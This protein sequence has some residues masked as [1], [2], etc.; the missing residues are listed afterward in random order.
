M[1]MM[2]DWLG[3][4][5]DPRRIALMQ[6]A[7]GLMGAKGGNLAQNIGQAGMMAIP[8]YQNAR[9]FNSREADAQL[10]RK[11]RQGQIDAQER[12]LAAQRSMDDLGRSAFA[13]AKTVQ[14]DP[15]EF[16]QM[17]QGTPQPQ[18]FSTPGG[19][20]LPA[21]VKGLMAIP[22]GPEKAIELQQRLAKDSPYGKLDPK[23]FTPESLR[24]FEASG[25]R[26]FTALRPRTKAEISNGV[27][28]DPY[29]T[30]PG[31]FI[32]GPLADVIPDGKGGW[33]PNP[34]KLALK[35][36]GA[37]NV[38]V[39]SGQAPFAKQ[40]GEKQADNIF[41]LHKSAGRAVETITTIH[42]MRDS[43]AGGMY[44]GGG[45]NTKAAI[46]NFLQPMGFAVNEDALAN[47]Q[48][49]NMAAG[50]FLLQHAKDLGANPSNADAARLDKIIGTAETNPQ[51]M[52]QLMDWQEE[53]ARRSIKKYNTVYDQV[54]KNPQI[55]NAYDMSVAEPGV[56]EPKQKQGGSAAP[57]I[58]GLSVTMPS[59]KVLTFPSEMALK[60][61]KKQAGI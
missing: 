39:T 53:M 44:T 28:Y 46:A 20:G 37:T 50:K 54:K 29:N 21:Y 52:N 42:Q 33:I 4:Q 40:F 45:A 58:N 47:T 27:A 13:E 7:F 51:A 25:R 6:M 43:M 59:G 41:D 2:G 15:Y 31:E 36:A 57:Q 38:T 14:P 9:A 10:D 61:W 18:P 19:G 60:A 12:A 55:F 1:S 5:N 32:T 30:K 3:D 34:A 49:F 23:D 35:K 16:D 26:D 11:Y 24:A 48:K 17:G 22:G 56:Y 8:A